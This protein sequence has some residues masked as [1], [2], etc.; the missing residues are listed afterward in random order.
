MNNYTIRELH[1]AAELHACVALQRD[2]WGK[3][4]AELVPAPIL[5]IAQRTGGVAAGAFDEGGALVGFVFGIT[6]VE[7]GDLVHWSDMLA[8]REDLRNRGIGEQLKRYQ[9]DVLRQRG[10]KRMYWTFDP[11]EAKNAYINFVRLGVT[12]HEYIRDMYGDSD[13]F[14]HKG[15]GTDR[16]VAVWELGSRH[17]AE[18][19]A[20]LSSLPDDDATLPEINTVQAEDGILHTS[21]PDLS[22]MEDRMVLHIPAEIQQVKQLSRDTAIEWRTVTRAA[23][24]Y[25][26]GRGYEV[27]DL[28]R[29][30]L[31]SSYVLAR[32]T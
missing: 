29:G 12:A 28:V 19:L 15:I 3:D 9:R 32:L 8:V 10:V 6:G 14:L 5:K 2:T 26:L 7:E 22:L 13:S 27:A 17:V 25:Y 11:L 23:L 1:G 30:D 4:F 21:R 18:R 20:G 24:E 16:L 31:R